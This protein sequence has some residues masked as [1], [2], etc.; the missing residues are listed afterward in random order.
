[1]QSGR[2]Q[3]PADALVLPSRSYMPS[4]SW[5]TGYRDHGFEICE[6]CITMLVWGIDPYVYMYISIFKGERG[7]KKGGRKSYLIRGNVSAPPSRFF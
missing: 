1:M 7:K 4:S 2:T 3:W 5:D 6:P